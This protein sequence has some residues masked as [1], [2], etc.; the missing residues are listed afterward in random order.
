M[1]VLLIA[2]LQ[3]AVILHTKCFPKGK[4]VQGCD[5]FC[6]YDLQQ[7]ASNVVSKVLVRH[8]CSVEVL[9]WGEAIMAAGPDGKVLFHLALNNSSA[10][11]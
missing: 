6:R 2:H 8:A 10:C 4:A 7:T 5:M 11:Q 1:Q 3:S 9:A